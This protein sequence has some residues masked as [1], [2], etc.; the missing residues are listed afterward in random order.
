MGDEGGRH[1][2]TAVAVLPLQHS[3]FQRDV[4]TEL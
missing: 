4:V 1:E 3:A 2:Q